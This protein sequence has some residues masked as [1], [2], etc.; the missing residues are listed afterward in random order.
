MMASAAARSA[1]ASWS[2][3]R[4]PV[5]HAIPVTPPPPRITAR[6]SL[7]GQHRDAC[8]V[9]Q[10]ELGLVRLLRHL[11]ELFGGKRAGQDDPAGLVAVVG[12][13][14]PLVRPEQAE[15]ELFDP[16]VMGVVRFAGDLE[17]AR[18]A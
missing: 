2:P 3:F 1:P 13:G 4:T 17:G 5:S 12:V 18:T 14:P 7:M 11:P 16:L 9:V 6:R 10:D 15:H 8:P